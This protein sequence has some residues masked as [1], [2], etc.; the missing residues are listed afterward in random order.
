MNNLTFMN[1]KYIFFYFIVFSLSSIINLNAQHKIPIRVLTNSNGPTQVTWITNIPINSAGCLDR[2]VYAGGIG[3]SGREPGIVKFSSPLPTNDV[4]PSSNIT[5]LR[6][7]NLGASGGSGS[8]PSDYVPFKIA[9]LDYFYF[10]TESPGY[11]IFTPTPRVQTGVVYRSDLSGFSGGTPRISN[12]PSGVYATNPRFQFPQKIKQ[13]EKRMIKA[14]NKVYIATER[15]LENGNVELWSMTPDG[16]TDVITS[17]GEICPGTTNGSFPESLTSVDISGTG[18]LF[19]T[20]DAGA[21]GTPDTSTVSPNREFFWLNTNTNIIQSADLKTVGGSNPINLV[22]CNNACYFAANDDLGTNFLYKSDGV[23]A[24]SKINLPVGVSVDTRA[25]PLINGTIIYFAAYTSGT[26]NLWR[27]DTSQPNITGT[28]P[29]IVD[30]DMTNPNQFEIIS[31]TLYFAADSTA[32]GREIFRSGGTSATTYMLA[33]LLPGATSSNPFNLTN[34]RGILYFFG[35]SGFTRNINQITRPTFY[36]YQYDPNLATS[37][38]NPNIFYRFKNNVSSTYYGWGTFRGNDASDVLGQITESN[39]N[40]YFSAAGLSDGATADDSDATTTARLPLGSASTNE[41]GLGNSIWFVEACPR[42]DIRYGAIIANN[43]VCQSVGTVSPIITNLVCNY[44]CVTSTFTSTA[45]LVLDNTTGA[46]DAAASTIGTYTVIFTCN[47]TGGCV[48]TTRILVTIQGS[49]SANIQVSTLAGDGTVGCVSGGLATSKFRFGDITAPPA[50]NI[51]DQANVSIARSP[52]GTKLYIADELNHVIRMVN[53]TTATSSILAGTCGAVGDSDGP[54]TSALFF[55]PSG[56]ATDAFG[57]IYVAD[58]GNHIIRKIDPNTGSVTTIAGV[59]TL[60][61]GD[62]NNANPLLAQFTQPSDLVV[63]NNGIIYVTDKNNQKIKAINPNTGVTTF[64]GSGVA[65]LTNATGVAAQFNRPSG[66]D[67]DAAGNLYVADMVNNVIRKITP[68]GV[69]TTLAAGFSF[70]TDVTIHPDGKLYVADRSNQVI[71]SINLTTSA[72]TTYAGSGTAGNF[73]APS[74]TAQFNFPSGITTDLSGKIYIVDRNNRTIRTIL[75]VNPAGDINGGTTVCAGTNSGTLTLVNF[76]NA[77]NPSQILRWESSIDNGVTWVNL[78]NGNSTTYNYT[79]ITQNTIFRVMFNESACGVLPS[80]TTKIL[81]NT[82][83]PPTVTPASACGVVPSANISLTLIASGGFAGDYVWYDASNVVIAGQNNGTLNVNISTTTS[84]FVSIKKNACESTKVGVTATVIPPPNPVITGNANACLNNVQTY[85]VTNVAGNIYNWTLP[86]GTGTI[87]S[88]QSTNSIN[89]TWTAGATGTVRV[90]QTGVT[91]SSCVTTSTLFNVTVN[92]KPT[93]TITPTSTACVGSVVSYSTPVISGRTYLWTITNGSPA[94]ATSANVSVTWGNF[95]TG[96]L[97]LRETITA[98]GCFVETT[99]IITLNPLPPTTITGNL[100]VCEGSAQ[101]YSVTAQ[102]GVTYL[103]T[104][105]G[106]TLNS[107]QGTNTASILWGTTGTGIVSVMQ[108]ITATSCNNTTN[109]NIIINPKPIPIITPTTNACKGSTVIYSTPNNVGSTY[110]WTVTGGTPTSGTGNTISVTW[111][112]GA[113]GTLNVNEIITATG[114]TANATPVTINLNPLPTPTITGSLTACQNAVR[115]YSVINSGNTYLWAVTGG[116]ITTGQGTNQV[117]ITWGIGVSGTLQVTETIAATTCFVSQTINV[118]IN[119]NPAPTFTGSNAVCANDIKTYTGTTTSGNTIN[120]VATGGAITSGQGTNSVSVTWGAAGAGTLVLSENNATTTCTGTQ[121]MNI[122]INPNPT[123]SIVG[124]TTVCINSSQNYSVVDA[125]GRTFLWTITGGTINSGQGSNGVN[126]TWATSPA[127]IQVRETN[128]ATTCFTQTNTNIIINAL[129]TPTITGSLNVCRNTT[130]NYSVV[131]APNTTYIWTVTNGTI[132]TGQNTNAISVIWNDLTATSGTVQI[133]QTNTLTNCIGTST[134]NVTIVPIPAPTFTGNASVCIGSS[135]TYTATFTAGNTLNWAVV[136]GTISS[137]QGTGTLVVLWGTN[138]TPTVTLTETNPLTTC[139]NSFVLPITINPNPTPVLT[140]AISVCANSTQ[141]YSVVNNVGSTYTWTI[142]NGTPATA[143]GNSVSV[144]WGNTATGT[145]VVRET[146]TATNCFI[147]VTQT[148]TI[149]ALPTPTITGS[150]AV[151]ENAVQNYSVPNLP[152]TTY[153]WAITGTGAVI[154]SGQNTNAISVTWGSVGAGTVAITQT[155]TTTTCVNTI[156]SNVTI[157]PNPNPIITGTLQVC[158]GATGVAYSVVNNVGSTYVW[159]GDA[160]ITIATGQNTNAITATIGTGTSA[161]LTVLETITATGCTKTTSITININGNPTN[162]IVGSLAVC[163]NATQLY[164]V[165]NNVGNTYAWTITGGTPA[166]AT[167][168]SVSIVWGNGTSGT[169]QVIETITATTCTKTYNANVTLIALPNPTITGSLAVCENAV[170]NYSVPNLPNNTYLWA[171]T[172]T[173]AVISSGQNTNAI[174]VTWGNAGSGT[175]AIT[176]T[177]TTTT[178]VNTITSN[179]TINPNPNPIITGTL[180]VCQGA[181]G[182]AYSVVNNVGS[183]YVWTGDANITIATGQ[184]TNAITA[185]IGTG[186]SAVLTVLETITATG[187]TKTTSITIN[188]NGNPTNTI[189]GSLAVCQNATQLYSVTNNVGNTYAWTITGG[190]PATATGNSVSIVWGNGTAGT[191]QVIETITAT[192]CSKTYNANVTLIALPSTTIAGTFSLC[193]DGTAT[194]TAPAAPNV[195]GLTYTYSWNIT[196]GT[197]VTPSTLTSNP[198]TVRWTDNPA[199]VENIRV[200]VTAVLN[201]VPTSCSATTPLPSGAGDNGFV[202]LNPIPTPIISGN[203]LVCNFST[204]TYSTPNLPINSTYT[205]TVLDGNGANITATAAVTGQ[206]TNSI[207]VTWG[208]AGTGK[209]RVQQT[210]PNTCSKTTLDYDVTIQAAPDA[211]ISP[212]RY[213]CGGAGTIT[214]TATHATATNFNWYNV[215]TNGTPLVNNASYVATITVSPTL[216]WVAAINTAGCEGAR[217][218]VTVTLDPANSQVLTSAVI[219]KADSCVAS[220]DS[221]SGRIILSLTGNNQNGPY[222]YLWSKVGVPAFN[223][224]TKDLFA[225][226]KGSY[227][228]A[229]TDGGGC[230]TNAGPFVVDETLAQITDGKVNGE[231]NLSVSIA[232]GTNFTLTATANN[233]ATY[234]WRDMNN[235]IVGTTANLLLTPSNIILNLNDNTGIY[236]VK[237]TNNRNC[238]IILTV[239]VKV[240]DLQ[241]FVPT[242]FTP[243]GDNKNDLMRVYGTG[244]KTVTF[245]IFNRLGELVFETQD[246][247]IVENQSKGWDGTFKGTLLQDGNYTWAIV[248]KFID[249]TDIKV[250]GRTTG[251]VLLMR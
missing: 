128:N 161:V 20:A 184:N 4:D 153:L 125:G 149:N 23:A 46:I 192:T 205:W 26:S 11:T 127:S 199:G 144:V 244:I 49:A 183:T 131:N 202:T 106:G 213:R 188:I 209:V 70:P 203:I 210:T 215:A 116:T 6:D 68:A 43:V 136:G 239:N 172:G 248:G 115:T 58:K 63:D 132:S 113:S 156:T 52:D 98:S 73:D 221:P 186:T 45:G 118:T 152:N 163:Q 235:N 177:N 180:Q 48:T 2:V 74:P 146:I 245:K 150:L 238:F 80:N 251:N 35:G 91:P 41:I 218:Q 138:A 167:G 71:K 216:F 159:T 12:A 187:C 228:V 62:V 94:T 100:S 227:N 225:I 24:P 173:G 189:V 119:P 207:N 139:N 10:L 229:I 168:N 34:I 212:D 82:I 249:D 22:S 226:T 81:V 15:Q 14:G 67:I 111:G 64:A 155:N 76:Q 124:N 230:V 154:S 214:L 50:G 141:N 240:V 32:S 224:I 59:P 60:G 129:P 97:L 96:T 101:S 107:G 44:P 25:K 84:Y 103:W 190:T 134:A 87:N 18:Y 169:I 16:T 85:S 236:T 37:A 3:S 117:D 42:S 27:F 120:W 19:F 95:A 195:T 79:N 8:K 17:L 121:T 133:Q 40:F 233:A 145:I 51:T 105:T 30:S 140:G 170:Q 232:K 231:A 176:Q 54:A 185:T 56:V 61:G 65:G 237:I 211:P 241:I 222:T 38:T 201:G 247:D 39:G 181:T 31:N 160:N 220:G 72:V 147:D 243:N 83:A 53:I 89:V 90:V 234:E 191:I 122:T 197:A 126:V 13:N 242:V 104:I 7:I 110:S 193:A 33:N 123:P 78:S 250:Q 174:S 21:L 112:N 5:P 9:G 55:R 223:A 102:A 28:N 162:T 143:T 178:C 151:C 158:Q 135:Q 194:Y 29:R 148:I 69:V 86:S 165:T 47:G 77:P 166:T 208:N 171:I 196:G 164:S 142:T 109:Q 175:V 182:V 179:V 93:P 75:T 246:F 108:T 137:G 99:Q 219:T 204:N 1:T 57:N 114:C 66:I 217:K 198:I 92:P 157:N 88:G 200:T 36:L 130:Q 206:A